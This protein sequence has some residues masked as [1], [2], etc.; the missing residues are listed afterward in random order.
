MNEYISWPPTLS[1]TSSVNGVGKGS[2]KQASF[3]FLKSTQILTSPEV[4]L[5]CITIWLTRYD[6]STCSITPTYII[7]SNSTFT[8][9]LY[10]GFNRYGHCLIGF[11][12]G[13]KGIFILVRSLTIPS[14]SENVG[15]RSQNSYNKLVTFIIVS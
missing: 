11:T 13:L 4:F 5:T 3:T 7:W 14:I 9:C 2:C 6:S 15:N 10:H 12:L 8:F 1:S